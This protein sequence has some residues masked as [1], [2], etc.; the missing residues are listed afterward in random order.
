MGKEVET[1]SGEAMFREV[2]RVRTLEI[3]VVSLVA[4]VEAEARI[5]VATCIGSGM[6]VLTRGCLLSLPISQC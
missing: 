2:Q 6:E 5:V 3:A 1:I 4:A